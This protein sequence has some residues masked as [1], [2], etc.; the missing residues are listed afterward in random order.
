MEF[1]NSYHFLVGGIGQ[2]DQQIVHELD[3]GVGVRIGDMCMDGLS[4]VFDVGF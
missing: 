1:D 3:L 4:I 2:T